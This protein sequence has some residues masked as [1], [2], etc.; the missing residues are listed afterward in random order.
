MAVSTFG[1]LDLDFYPN[2]IALSFRDASGSL[3]HEETI[4]R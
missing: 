3:L 1:R 4:E 2:R